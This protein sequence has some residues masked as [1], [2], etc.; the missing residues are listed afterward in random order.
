MIDSVCVSGGD[1]ISFTKIHKYMLQKITNLRIKDEI[2]SKNQGLNQQLYQ[3]HLHLANTWDLT[4]PY[5][6][7]TIEEKLQKATRNKYGSLNKKLEHL[8]Q[9]QTNAPHERCSFHPRVVNHTDISFSNSEMSLL[10]KGPKYNI[11]GKPRNW[12]QNMGLEADTTISQLPTNER[13][14][15]R[16]IVAE[17]IHTLQQ[18]NTS[19]SIHN[20]HPKTRLIKSIKSKLNSNQA[21]IARV[22]KG[23]SIVILPTQ[24]YESKIQDFLQNNNFI[25]TTKD[26]TNTFQAEIKNTIKHSKTLILYDSRWKYTNLNPSAPSIKGLIK[27]HKQGLPIRPVVNWRNAPAYQL[28]RLFTQE[29]N[30]I[31][32]LPYIFNVKNTTDLL[33]KL[34][35]TP[36]APHFTLVSLDITNL[37]SNIPV[38]ETR[39]ILADTVKY[40]QTDPQTQQELLMWY[41]VITRQ[42]YFAHNQDVISQHDGLAMGAPSLGL[43]A[44]LFLQHTENTHLAHLSHKHRIIDYFRYVDD[45]LLIFDPNHTDIQTILADFNAIHPNLLFTAEIEKDNTIS[46]LDISIQ[47]T[48]QKLIASIYRKPA[49]TNSVIPYTSNHPAQHKYAAVKFLYNRLNSNKNSASFTTSFTTIRSQLHHKDTPPTTQHDNNGHKIPNTNGQLSPTQAKK[50]YALLMFLNIRT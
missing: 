33:Q 16:K 45:I 49:F 9:T 47:K 20:T 35:N 43:I 15:Y 2:H 46:F 36:M 11:H 7:R 22:D 32:P 29:I 24:Q 19:N 40:H 27:L 8:S 41:S 34:Q 37:Y 4:W 38:K 17:R 48:P 28:S 13:E 21:M 31:A 26:P 39:T 50:P 6:Q 3:L 18:N 5:I 12:I 1:E 44:E 14:T 23:N 42:N 30:N 10:Q 25:T